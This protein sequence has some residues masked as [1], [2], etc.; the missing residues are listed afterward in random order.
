MATKFDHLRLGFHYFPDTLHYQNSDLNKW[1]P[2]LQELGASWITLIAPI[3]RAI[4][5][6][7]LKG[8]IDPSCI[9]MP[10]SPQ[11]SLLR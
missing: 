5:E 11:Q 2:I 7:F 9:F 4:P 10:L 1:L 3:Q 8:L 6:S